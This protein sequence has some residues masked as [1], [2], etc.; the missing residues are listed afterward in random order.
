M[1]YHA[2]FENNNP[3]NVPHASPW[4]KIDSSDG[5]APRSSTCRV[6][7]LGAI[8]CHGSSHSRLAPPIAT[9]IVRHPNCAVIVPPMSKPNAGPSLEPASMNAFARPRSRSGKF[10][11]R[12]F[13]Y[14][15]YAIDSAMPRN[16]RKMKMLTNPPATPVKTVAV[17]QTAK[18]IAYSRYT[19]YRSMAQPAII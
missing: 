19:L 15:G 12:I 6:K 8:A 13:E 17:D 7:S 11:A 18:Q 10:A 4:R 16:R 1:K 9:N 5:P 14:A 3:K 2:Q